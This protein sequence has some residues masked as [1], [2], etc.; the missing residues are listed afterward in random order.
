MELCHRSDVSYAY[1]VPAESSS[2]YVVSIKTVTE[3]ELTTVQV[4]SINTKS[5]PLE[6]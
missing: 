4:M 3:K 5:V 2:W 1:Y 6:Q